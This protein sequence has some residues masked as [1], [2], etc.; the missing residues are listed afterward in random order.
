MSE[1]LE[2]GDRVIELTRGDITTEPVEMIANAANAALAGGGGVDGAIHAAAGPEV[3]RELR[4]TYPAGTPTG[5]AVVTGAGALTARWIAHAVGPIWRGGGRG[6]PEQLASAYRS[7]LALADEHGARTLAFPA[8]SLG[9]YGYPAADGARVALRA[10][11]D[12]LAGST[13]IEL[14]RFVLRGS[15]YDAFVVALS[16]LASAD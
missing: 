10:V 4:T 1:R 9:I 13:G 15:I 14:V 8:I 3:M 16:E 5:S 6:E 11:R 2:I 7:V 12:H